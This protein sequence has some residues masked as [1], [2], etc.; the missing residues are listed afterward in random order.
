MGKFA[1]GVNSKD[2]DSLPSRA[3]NFTPVRVIFWPASKP[4]STTTGK[5]SGMETSTRSETAAI[6]SPTSLATVNCLG[7]KPSLY[8]TVAR[9]SRFKAPEK[10]SFVNNFKL[11]EDLGSQ[12]NNQVFVTSESSLA[13]WDRLKVVPTSLARTINKTLAPFSTPSVHA[14]PKAACQ[15]AELKA[16]D[17]STPSALSSVPTT[18]LALAVPFAALVVDVTGKNTS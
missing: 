3:L 14:E 15:S 7:V 1:V 8:T 11:V 18:V 5:V 17:M 13:P 6:L 10:L 2:T 16:L 9:I 4:V 12:F